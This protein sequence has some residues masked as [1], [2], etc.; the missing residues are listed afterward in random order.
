MSMYFQFESMS[1]A[2]S[3]PS[4]LVGAGV[5]VRWVLAGVVLGH[6][7]RGSV[8][9]VSCLGRVSLSLD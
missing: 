1:R 9:A 4:V 8:M 6:W 2:I 5:A 3:G 7:T